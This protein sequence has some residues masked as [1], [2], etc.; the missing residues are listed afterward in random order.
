MTDLERAFTACRGRLQ[1]LAYRM[2]GSRA[3]AEDVVHDAYLRVK[4]AD[5]TDIRNAEAFLVTT[6]TRICLDQLKSARAKREVYV[7][8]WLPEP[9]LDAEA[10][11]PDS[12][13]EIADDLSF[14]LLLTL[15]KLSAPERAAFLLHDVFDTPFSQIA[16]AIGKSE[17]ACRQL[18]ARARKAVRS[19]RPSRPAP[20]EAHE[21]LLANFADALA[22][23]DP[24]RLKALLTEDVVAYSD[25]GGV[26]TAALKP[27]K[28]AENV[29]RF[30]AGL[31]RKHYARGGTS[32]FELATINGA[33]GFVT[34]LDGEFDHTMCL[35]VEGDRIAAIYTVRNPEKLRAIHAV[36]H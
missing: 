4:Q 19:A 15:E 26:K 18:A 30:F 24:S 10:M 8:P 22:T 17:A 27:V 20:P 35:D 1:G 29:A 14:A 7:G 12:A 28:G 25:G 33:P 23:G 2:L 6:V 9:V 34:Y 3:D 16:E 36:F 13:A 31:V 5:R 11:T 32:H 21:A